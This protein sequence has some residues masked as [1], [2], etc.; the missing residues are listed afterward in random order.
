MTA[1]DMKRYIWTEAG[2]V[3][4]CAE[5]VGRGVRLTLCDWTGKPTSEPIDLV[6]SGRVADLRSV[7]NAALEAGRVA[8]EKAM[9]FEETT[10]AH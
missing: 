3:M 9:T 1:F 10:D 2:G 6:L 8:D 4:L 5:V 7:C